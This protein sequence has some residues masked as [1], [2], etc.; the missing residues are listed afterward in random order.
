MRL[1]ILL[2]VVLSVLPNQSWA[3]RR[4][5]D[6][7]PESIAAYFNPPSEFVGDFGAYK[8]PLIF[9]DG[10]KIKTRYYACGGYVTKGKAVCERSVIRKEMVEDLV[11]LTFM[12]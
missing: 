12:F 1:S 11:L 10:T 9:D 4:G 5:A 2:S 3:G 8:S 6:E 7:I